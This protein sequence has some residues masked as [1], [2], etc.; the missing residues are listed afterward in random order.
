MLKTPRLEIRKMS[1][2][3]TGAVFEMRSDPEVMRYIR[4]PQGWGETASWVDLISS[5][6]ESE[7]LGFCALIE[8][9]SG[10][11]A[12]WAGL[13]KLKET[14]EIEVGY[15]IAKEFWGRGYASEAAAAFLRYGF[16][17]LG[18]EKIVAVAMPEN[19]ASRR[20]ME[21]IGMKYGH[22]GEYYGLELVYY[23]IMKEEWLCSKKDA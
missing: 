5:K 19:L 14:G 15:G 3:D 6:W 21:K 1:G 16:I 13:W 23:S 17:G 11:F 2:E 8:E 7:R 20:V 9:A 18:L 22:I 12:G 10:K 4:E